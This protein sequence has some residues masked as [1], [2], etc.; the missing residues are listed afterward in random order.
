MNLRNFLKG[1]VASVACA[2]IPIGM[3]KALTVED[4]V[5]TIP[6]REST[7]GYHAEVQRWEMRMIQTPFGEITYK[8]HPLA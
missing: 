1:I 2:A 6:L 8:A 5:R 7:S 3:K 4:I